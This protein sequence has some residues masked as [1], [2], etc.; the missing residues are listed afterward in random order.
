MKQILFYVSL[1]TVVFLFGCKKSNNETSSGNCR[2][3]Q[4]AGSM[5]NVYCFYN[6]NSRISKMRFISPPS[7]TSWENYFY[8]NDH[9]A[10]MI[11]LYKGTQGDTI[12]YTY[13]SGKYT[14]VNQYGFTLKYVYDNFN[15]LIKIERHEDSVV[16]SYSDYL[17]DSMGNCTKCS[18][19]SWTGTS[20]IWDQL[21]DFEFGNNKN[22]YSSIGLPPLNSMGPEI[23]MYNSPN[24]ITKMRTQYPQTGK[25]VFV[26]TY[27]IFNANRYPLTFSIGDSLNHI[28]SNETM[29][30]VCP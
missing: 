18:Q 25:L 4:S 5:N 1:F 24:N 17:Y 2:M 6:E 21:T 19:Y 10:Y 14:E 7:D 22:P 26:Y 16:S 28:M 11:R 12:S 27:S 13:K 9:V 30:Y 23:G 3:Q 20:Y 8:E 29:E 15:R